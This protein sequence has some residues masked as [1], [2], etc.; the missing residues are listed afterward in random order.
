MERTRRVTHTVVTLGNAVL[1]SAL[2]QVGDLGPVLIRIG[3][4]GEGIIVLLV[5][6]LS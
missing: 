4:A 6:V 1:Y 5:I 2:S 3:R